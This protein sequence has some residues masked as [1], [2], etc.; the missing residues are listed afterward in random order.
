[1]EHDL[2]VVK[3]MPLSSQSY[4]LPDENPARSGPSPTLEETLAVP[5]AEV[6]LLSVS[7]HEL[8]TRSE[9]NRFVMLREMLPERH[10]LMLT[11]YAVADYEREGAR[12][13][14][15]DNNTGGFG[16]LPSKEIVSV[17]SLPG[18][19]VGR[20]LIEDAILRGGRRVECF[21]IGNKLPKLYA[22]FGFSEVD[23]IPWDDNHSPQSWDFDRY[24]TPD[25]VVLDLLT[26]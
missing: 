22:Q 2:F 9:R 8:D 7:V 23:R 24:G 14:L 20:Y 5:A 16:I 3:L 4:P 19:R 17:F 18:T 11:P 13:F 21:D 26:Q 12:L 25:V 10:R 6:P 15:T 1:M